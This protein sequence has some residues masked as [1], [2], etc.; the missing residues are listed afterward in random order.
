MAILEKNMEASIWGLCRGIGAISRVIQGYMSYSL[1]S[2]RWVI[3]G[4]YIQ[5]FIPC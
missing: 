4:N 3:L 1:N 2:L 5:P